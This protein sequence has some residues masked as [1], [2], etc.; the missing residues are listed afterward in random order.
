M[1]EKNGTHDAER[2][3]LLK[4]AALGLKVRTDTKLKV[5]QPLGSATIVLSEPSLAAALEPHVPVMAVPFT[6]SAT[7]ANCGSAVGV[8]TTWAM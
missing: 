5:R 7:R 6:L 8:V 2:R 4:I 3:R 1:S